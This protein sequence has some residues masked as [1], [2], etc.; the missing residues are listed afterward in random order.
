MREW[1]NRHAW[2]ACDLRKRSVGSNPT[3]SATS[4]ASGGPARAGLPARRQ[5]GADARPLFWRGR[6]RRASGSE[7]SHPL[8]YFSSSR[9][10]LLEEKCICRFSRC[11]GKS[12]ENAKDSFFR[13]L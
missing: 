2:R 1:I 11:V 13:D 12:A 7:Q 3:L 10:R 5:E 9:L 4:E 6:A 8:R